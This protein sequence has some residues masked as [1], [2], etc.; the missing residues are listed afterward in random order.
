MNGIRK[1]ALEH[2]AT[3][4]EVV[5]RFERMLG[6]ARAL[7]GDRVRSAEQHGASLPEIAEATG[8]SEKEAAKLIERHK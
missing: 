8:L 5:R 1:L 2:A 6:T 7:L 3:Q 4:A